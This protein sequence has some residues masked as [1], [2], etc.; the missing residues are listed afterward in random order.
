MTTAKII[1]QA[2]FTKFKQEPLLVRS[3]GR[4]NLI[5]EHTDYNDGLV[6][7]GAIDKELV[8]A[9]APADGDTCCLHANDLQESI[10]FDAGCGKPADHSWARYL[11]AVLQELQGYGECVTA[12]NCT[13][14]GNLPPGAGLASSAALTTGFALALNQLFGLG[15]DRATLARICQQAEHLT[16]TDCGIMDQYAALFG[17]RNN[18]V[19][20]DCRSLS[21]Q[22]IPFVHE[23]VRI[24]L[25]NTGVTHA[26]ADS[27]YNVRRQECRQG[28]E[29]LQRFMPD[30]ESLRD[31]TLTTLEKAR[32]ELGPKLYARS[33]YIVEENQRVRTACSLLSCGDIAGLGQIMFATHYGLRDLYE[34]SCPELDFLVELAADTEGVVGAR[35]MGG[36]FGG[37]T[38]NLVRP[39]ASQRFLENATAYFGNSFSQNLQAYAVQLSDGASVIR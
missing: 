35:M 14:G 8:F 27:E 6:L 36:G 20:L 13:F 4:I 16:G 33:R 37:C 23:E 15:L 30:L 32:E 24:V 25:L 26:L 38:I 19:L 2:F 1:E 7:P 11:Q 31:V 12:V 10:E 29:I 9:V 34:V 17:Q 18:L 5:G 39:D 3:P 28:I 21:V 22:H